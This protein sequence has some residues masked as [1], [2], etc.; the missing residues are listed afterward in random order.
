MSFFACNVQNTALDMLHVRAPEGL[1]VHHEKPSA[2]S[3]ASL[4]PLVSARALVAGFA[5]CTSVGV[6][7]LVG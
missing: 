1:F 4:A 6:D 2:P 5:Q 7:T 3:T